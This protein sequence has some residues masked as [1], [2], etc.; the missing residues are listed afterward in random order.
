MFAANRLTGTIPSCIGGLS[1]LTTLELFVNSMSGTIP[2]SLG[3]LGNLTALYLS[4][5]EF[6][7]EIPS[8]L[9]SM[10]ALEVRAGC[11]PHVGACVG[12]VAASAIGAYEQLSVVSCFVVGLTGLTGLTGLARQVL[13]L[14]RNRL[15]GT[16]P[17]GIAGLLQVEEL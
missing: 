14:Q 5:N 10:M 6:T 17:A 3:A 9:G 7:G 16:V 13:W 8:S 1:Q 2:A 12:G 4:A 15:V 11:L